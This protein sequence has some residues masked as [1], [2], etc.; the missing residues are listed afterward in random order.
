M[1][2][3]SPFGGQTMLATAG[4]GL[5]FPHHHDMRAAGGAVGWC[6]I[7]PENYMSASR[8]LRVLEDIRRD[9]PIALHAVG[10]SLGS[11]DAPDPAHLA[12]LRA[13]I[14]RIEP[15]LASD[16]LSWSI[17]DGVYLADLLP[18]PYTEEALAVVVRNVDA[19][20]EALGRQVLIE[21]PSSY[22]T[23]TH[24]TLR[25]S[26]FLAAVA[27]RTGCGVLLDVNNLY[28]SAANHGWS[29]DAFL[30]DLAP[31]SIGEIHLA[32]HSVTTL[33]NGDSI[34]IDD[35][36]SAVDDAVWA[37]YARTI[38]RFGARPTLI[39]W[40]AN[41][42]EFSVL[43]AEAERAQAYLDSLSLEQRHVHAA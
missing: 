27:A 41:I 2:V 3:T 33:P 39:E 9:R 11:A 8:G 21:N 29:I 13:M 15:S 16:H 31:H 22:L 20:Q 34:R 25:E 24:S 38:A 36:G 17:I 14:D 18:L 19:A 30:D 5:R 1:S 35:H 10:L 7:H 28:V 26:E 43:V 12:R 32:G 4:I 23:F 6:E 40:D 37:L 42:P